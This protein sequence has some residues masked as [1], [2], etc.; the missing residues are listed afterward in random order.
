MLLARTIGITPQSVSLWF[1]GRLPRRVT[2]ELLCQ[3]LGINI[4]WL[5]YGQGSSEPEL[6]EPMFL[7]WK[8]IE[9]DLLLGRSS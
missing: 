7:S 6:Q 4:E 8:K 5:L 1:K 9:K 3:K 2:M